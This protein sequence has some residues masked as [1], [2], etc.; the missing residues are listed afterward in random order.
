MSSPPTTSE[1][2]ERIERG[3]GDAL[4]KHCH[5]SLAMNNP[6]MLGVSFAT[7]DKY[8]AE[9]GTLPRR[10]SNA[11]MPEQEVVGTTAAAASKEVPAH[12]VVVLDSENNVTVTD[13]RGRR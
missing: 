12:D 3:G 9:G 11:R 1:I 2:A 4:L 10:W 5:Q 7:L 13:K 6:Q 8:L